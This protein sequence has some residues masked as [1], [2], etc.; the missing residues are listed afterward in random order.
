MLGEV[1]F[2]GKQPNDK[3]QKILGEGEFAAAAFPLWFSD[4][5]PKKSSLPLK[6]PGILG[7]TAAVKHYLRQMAVARLRVE[8]VMRSEGNHFYF[9]SSYVSFPKY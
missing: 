5:T 7:R 6:T 3:K 2:G 8:A 1:N 4:V 9:D